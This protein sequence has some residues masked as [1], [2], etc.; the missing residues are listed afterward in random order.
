MSQRSP[1]IPIGE[2]TARTEPSPMLWAYTLAT[3][4]HPSPPG[5]H[6][7]RLPPRCLRDLGGGVQRRTTNAPWMM[8]PPPF[9]ENRTRSAPSRNPT[10]SHCCA[11]AGR[12]GADLRC[13]VMMMVSVTR[14]PDSPETVVEVALDAA[15]SR[16]RSCP[17]IF[18]C[19]WAVAEAAHPTTYA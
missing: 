15:R 13:T 6:L 5:S 4:R 18:S 2:T 17:R 11:P 1:S 10:E 8:T 12:W 19:R 16:R 7:R 14:S 3:P 9:P